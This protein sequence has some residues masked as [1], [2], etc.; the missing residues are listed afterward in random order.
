MKITI[1]ENER[2]FLLRKGLFVKM[3]SSGTHRVWSIRDESC[4][5]VTADGPVVLRDLEVQVLLGNAEFAK[6]CA[7]AEVGDSQL[8]LHYVD[9][10]LKEALGT[11]EHLFW[12][13]FHKHTFELVDV[14]EPEVSGLSV[15]QMRC[16]ASNLYT[17]LEV[18]NGTCALLHY[19]G[20]FQRRLNAGSYYFWNGAVRVQ[21][22]I[23]DLRTQA[24]EL[25]GQEILTADKVMLRVN[26]AC[27]YQIADPEA[28]VAGIKDHKTLLHT[29]VQLVLREQIGRLRLDELLAQKESIGASVLAKLREKEAALSVV[30]GES[31]IKDIILPGEIR[32]IMNTVLIAEK[33]AQANVIARREETASTRDLLNTAKLMDENQTLYKLKEMECLERIC[34]KVG[35]ISVG[36]GDLLGE[37]K[38]LLAVKR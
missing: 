15:A 25:A 14:R 4:V 35:S 19:D 22:A 28:V 6:A 33:R 26:F 24:L 9:G 21:A 12:N 23:C 37:L 29:A 17:R 34:D 36:G 5:K 30:F 1:R 32:D 18:E 13:I 3:L 7:R 31:G 8:A 27:T 38:G 11:G 10:R 16:I 2:G 20:V